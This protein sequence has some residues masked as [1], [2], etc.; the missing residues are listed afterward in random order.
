MIVVLVVEEKKTVY[1]L[2]SVEGAAREFVSTVNVE[3]DMYHVEVTAKDV[4]VE[5]ALKFAG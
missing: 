1:R 2:K 5:D 3:M 4:E